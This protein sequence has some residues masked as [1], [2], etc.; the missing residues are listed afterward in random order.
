[1]SLLRSV[2]SVLSVA[3]LGLL[4]STSACDQSPTD[5]DGGDGVPGRSPRLALWLAKKDELLA[6]DSAAYDLVMTGWFESDEAQAIHEDHA[7]AQLLAGLTLN[8]VSGDPAWQ[9]LLVTVANNGDPGGPLQ[10]TDDMFLMYDTDEDGELDTRC[11][12]PGWEDPELFAM[13]P[14]HNGWQELVVSFYDVAASQPHHDGVIV[15][16]VD[17][18]PF[19][20]GAASG[21]VPTPIGPAEWVTAQEELLESVRESVP[22]HKWVIANAGCGF[23]DASPFPGHT[24][25]FLLEN[26]LGTLCG[27][28]VPQLLAAAEHALETTEPPHIIV[29]AVD[30]DNTGQ[31]DWPRFRTGLVLSLLLDHTYFA[32]DHGTLDHGD[33]SGYWFPE[34]Y[35]VDLGDPV[36]SYIEEEGVYSRVFENGT[37]VAAVDTAAFVSLDAVHVRVG[38]QESGTEFHVS[39]GDAAIFLGM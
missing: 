14:R 37:I 22:D 13:V 20:D 27:T 28:E 9:A 24:N 30:T 2:R 19:C 12:F 34:Y 29:F 16:M 17:A 7:E 11:T 3:A 23:D 10:I 33:V 32:F 15:D 18:Y 36:D 6:H 5:P 21:G 25:G 35:D 38:T 31:I 4:L 39:R 1:M 26:A 8:W